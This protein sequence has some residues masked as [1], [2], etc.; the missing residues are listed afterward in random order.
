MDP[1]QA[2]RVGS[3]ALGLGAALMAGRAAVRLTYRWSPG[4]LMLEAAGVLIVVALA[5]AVWRP[6][7][8]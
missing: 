1:G 6:R 5:V 4:A 2:A 3:V 8:W 7:R